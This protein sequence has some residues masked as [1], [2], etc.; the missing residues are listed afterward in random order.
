MV[1]DLH[2]SAWI[3]DS[4]LSACYRLSSP[5]V[6]Y[7]ENFN[8]EYHT[9]ISIVYCKLFM[10][11]NFHGYTIKSKFAGKHSRLTVRSS[12]MDAGPTQS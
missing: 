5:V 12:L 8:S 2:M 7:N 6:Q 4:E 9:N 1:V 11:E 10:V 3:L